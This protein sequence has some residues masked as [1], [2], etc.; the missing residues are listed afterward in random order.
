MAVL[1][2]VLEVACVTGLAAAL[3]V[4][5]ATDL[6]RRIIPNGCVAV[7]AAL[8]AARAAARGTLPGA[9]LGA[10]VV[11]AAMLLAAAASERVSGRPGVG[12]GDVKLLAAAAVWTGPVLGL[13]V[14]GASC[15]LGAMGWAATRLAGRLVGRGRTSEGIPLAPAVAIATLAAVLLGPLTAP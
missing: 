8:G 3:G 4:A 9:A 1:T 15:L 10:L 12:G 14:V 2:A 5:A 7:V 13:A 11:L 6:A